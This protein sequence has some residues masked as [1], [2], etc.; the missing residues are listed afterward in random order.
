MK[1]VIRKNKEKKTVTPVDIYSHASGVYD[2]SLAR[3]ATR[4]T[5]TPGHGSTT[6]GFAA[7]IIRPRR[8]ELARSQRV[9]RLGQ[10]V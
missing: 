4:L 1:A 2:V 7:E 3:P 10:S 8:H 9:L 5:M 6:K